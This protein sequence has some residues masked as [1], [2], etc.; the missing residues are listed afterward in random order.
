MQDIVIVCAGTYGIEQYTEINEIN[1]ILISKG[2]PPAYRILGFLSDEFVDLKAKKVNAEIIGSIND[3]EIKGNEK[4]VV[5]LSRPVQKK[6]VVSILKEK[7]ACFE[8]IISPYAYVSKDIRIGE[9]CF[10]SGG[11]RVSC[12]VKLGNFVN[13]NGSMICGGATIK[14]YSTTTGYTVIEDATID[15]G[16]FIGSK[17]VITSG[18]LVGKWSQV[19]AG[20]IVVDNVKSEV[21]VFGMPAQEIG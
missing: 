8:T 13:I 15:E 14:D 21:I 1:R 19:S 17:S 2:K 11:S 6:K 12:G 18:C 7:G 20:S 5:G 16:V 3:W 9:G 10:I 4:Y